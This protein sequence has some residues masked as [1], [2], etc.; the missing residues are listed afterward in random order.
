M[1]P[2]LNSRI[3]TRN[4]QKYSARPQPSGNS[5]EGGRLA[6]RI[7]SNSRPWLPQSASECTASASIAP[8]PVSSAANDLAMKIAKFAPSASRIAFSELA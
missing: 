6:W 7:P 8:E 1:P 5:S 2:T 3:A 4:D